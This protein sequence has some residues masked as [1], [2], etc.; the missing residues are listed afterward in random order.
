MRFWKLRRT[1]TEA[2]ILKHFDLARPIILQHNASGFAIAG[3]RNPSNV[4]GVLR[5]VNVYSTKCSSAAQIYDN[6][7]RELSAIVDTLKQWRHYLEGTNDKVS[8][9]CDHQ[10]LDYFQTSKV[11]SRWQARG[12]ETLSADDFVIELLDPSYNPA[13]SP[14]RWPHY[15]GAYQWPVAQPFQT[16]SV[17]PYDVLMRAIIVPHA[18]EPLVVEVLAK[19]VDHRII[20]HTDTATEMSQWKVDSGVLTYKGRIYVPAINSLHGKVINL[21][22]DNPESSH[23]GSLMNTDLVSGNFYWPPMHSLVRKYV[24]GCYV[25][26][27]IT[28]PRHA[29]HAINTHLEAPLSPCEGVMRDFVADLVQST[30]WGYTG[31]LI[32]VDQLT[33]MAICLPFRKDIDSPELARLFLQHVI[34]KGGIPDNIVTDLGTQSPRPFRIGLCSHLGTDH[35]LATVFH[36]HRDGQTEHQSQT[37]EQYLRAFCNYEQDNWVEFFRLAKLGCNNAI[38]A[39]MRMS[40]FWGNYHYH[41]VMHFKAP[42][43]PFSLNSQIQAET[44][45]AG[46]EETDQTVHNNMKEAQPNQKKD[47]GGNNVIFDVGDIVWLSTRHFQ[48]TRP[49]MMLDHTRSGLRKVSIV[50]NKNAYKIGLPYTVRN[51]ILVHVS[52]LDLFTP[53]TAGQ[54]PPEQQPTVVD[55]S[56]KCDVNQIRNCKRHYRK[57]NYLVQWTGYS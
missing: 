21:L 19:L 48:M 12:A 37:I 18:F 44:F 32:I 54:P 16:V 6:Y 29:R 38:H 49:A 15:N 8:I 31:I 4:C 1:F 57:L 2:L 7:D 46:L 36:P 3:I 25:C 51:H 40:P 50:I 22:H 26:H 43:Q 24:S 52:V 47:A 14:S 53:P 45:A 9:W 5:P 39:S 28:V 55:D 10:D 20:D 11:L 35:R 42:K 41:P 56:D 27:Q 13:D 17:E 33:K 23:F 30:A 34:C